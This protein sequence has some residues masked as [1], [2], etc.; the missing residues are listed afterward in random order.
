MLEFNREIHYALHLVLTL[1]QLP[2]GETLSLRK[3]SKNNNISFLFLQRIA[4]KL[5]EVK[6]IQAVKGAHGGYHLLAKPEKLTVKSIVDAIDGQCALAE[7]LR[8]GYVCPRQK[9]CR[10]H[11]VFGVINEHLSNYLEN[12]FLTDFKKYAK[13]PAKVKS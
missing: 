11:P 8:S 10:A 12:F 1:M 13:E 7:C 9:F 5:R 3:F 4:K 2:S 6:I